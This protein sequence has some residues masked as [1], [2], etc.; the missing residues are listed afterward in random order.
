MINKL[1]QDTEGKI[2]LGDIGVYAYLL[3]LSKADANV[4]LDMVTSTTK[5]TRHKFIQHLKALE[6][7]GY[8][9]YTQTNVSSRKSTTLKFDFELLAGNA[10][11]ANLDPRIVQLYMALV[12]ADGIGLYA[13]MQER[14]SN[15]VYYSEG[16]RGDAKTLNMSTT[17]LQKVIRKLIGYNMIEKDYFKNEQN[18]TQTCYR[19]QGFTELPTR[20]I[21]Q[22]PPLARDLYLRAVGEVV[23]RDISVYQYKKG[24]Y[25]PT[26][27]NFYFE[28]KHP[29]EALEVDYPARIKENSITIMLNGQFVAMSQLELDGGLVIGSTE[30]LTK[31]ALMEEANS[32][33]ADGGVVSAFLDVMRKLAA[34]MSNVDSNTLPFIIL[35]ETDE[36]QTHAHVLIKDM[37]LNDFNMFASK[38]SWD[39]TNLKLH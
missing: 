33:S 17:T 24:I 39:K 38:L 23:C 26:L 7:F 20:F 11:L 27:R 3:S 25:T 12:G 18:F 15:G 16:V 4:T 30:E 2:S 28:Y 22:L 19:L 32:T 14:Q 8:L 35:E 31:L 9:K 10:S 6:L 13:F 36:T 37:W 1:L 21:L 29:Q 34:R 5:L